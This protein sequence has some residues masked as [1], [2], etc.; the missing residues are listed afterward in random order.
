MKDSVGAAADVA[1]AA[2]AWDS[3]WEGRTSYVE[4]WVVAFVGEIGAVQVIVVVG[5][6]VTT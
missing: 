5:V 1:L 4:P 3:N 2:D 6:G